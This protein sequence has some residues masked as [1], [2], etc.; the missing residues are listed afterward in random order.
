MKN[1]DEIAFKLELLN[2]ILSR[3]KTD[4]Q[5]RILMPKKDS[6]LLRVIGKIK[7]NKK[8]LN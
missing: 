6:E 1:I 7:Y 3:I 8:N 5:G 2:V 4:K